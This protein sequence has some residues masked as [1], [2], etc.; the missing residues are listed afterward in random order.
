MASYRKYQIGRNVRLAKDEGLDLPTES[1]GQVARI[2]SKVGTSEYLVYTEQNGYFSVCNY[3]IEE[4][5]VLPISSNF[6]KTQEGQLG[7]MYNLDPDGMASVTLYPDVSELL[8]VNALTV[9][10]L[11]AWYDKFITWFGFVAYGC[12][13]NGPCSCGNKVA[14]SIFAPALRWVH[15]HLPYSMLVALRYI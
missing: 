14:N 10:Y 1:L 4:V 15:D 2:S 9:W 6:F 12:S 11:P 5:S 13:C 3:H 8:P 7:Y